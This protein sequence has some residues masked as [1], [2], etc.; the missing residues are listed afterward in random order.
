MNLRCRIGFHKWDGCECE[1][2][3]SMRNGGHSWNGCTCSKC[4]K[5]KHDWIVISSGEENCSTCGGSGS[6]EQKSRRQGNYGTNGPDYSDLD[7][8]AFETI[9]CGSCS[10]TGKKFVTRH[11]C[12]NCGQIYED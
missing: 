11:K 9:T 2:C 3:G 8:D 5:A 10:G 12:E 4:R 6:Y 7:P 1:L